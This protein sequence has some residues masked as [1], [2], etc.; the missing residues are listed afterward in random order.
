VG[1]S[2]T[3]NPTMPIEGGIVHVTAQWKARAASTTV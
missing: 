3:E 2:R 1:L